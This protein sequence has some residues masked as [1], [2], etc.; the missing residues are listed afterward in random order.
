[1]T[2][3]QKKKIILMGLGIKEEDAERI[4]QKKENTQFDSPT[5]Q[6]KGFIL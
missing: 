2:P 5:T 1:M 6:Y 3:A 4:S